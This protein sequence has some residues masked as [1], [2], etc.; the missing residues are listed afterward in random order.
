MD[1]KTSESAQKMRTTN[2]FSER[3]P[4]LNLLHFSPS[5]TPHTHT[6]TVIQK[7]VGRVKLLLTM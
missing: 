3:E 1:N 2:D 6:Y 7:H 4:V 5:Y